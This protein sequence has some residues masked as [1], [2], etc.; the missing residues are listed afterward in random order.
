M[1]NN[2]DVVKKRSF[3]GCLT[4][5]MRVSGGMLCMEKY[6]IGGIFLPLLMGSIFNVD[7]LENEIVG[8]DK[9]LTVA[10]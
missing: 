4:A 8:F 5:H 1:D 6:K 10:L 9:N 2:T 7:F 3:H